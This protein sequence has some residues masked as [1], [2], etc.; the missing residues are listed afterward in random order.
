MRLDK[1]ISNIT[2]ISRKEIKK[3]CKENRVLV[4]GDVITDPSFKVNEETD[5]VKIDN[6]RIM[7]KKFVYYMLNK[8]KDC[9]CATND[10]KHL[11]VINLIEEDEYKDEIFP[12]GRLDKDTVGLLLITNDGM[13]AHNLLSPVKH[14]DKKYFV[15]VT[16][17]LEAEH[18]DVFKKGIKL[19]EDFITKP[20]K[21]EIL[22][23]SEISEAYVTIS[24]GKFHQIKRMF[25]SMGMVVIYLKRI[26]MGGLVLDENLDEGS[27]RELTEE[28]VMNL[29]NR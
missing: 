14:V 1:M 4:N 20:A 19:E 28:E 25:L 8:P 16:G 27:Y 12:V 21:L 5:V 24:E 13:L 26:S 15:R 9:I 2:S 6:K 10:K 7:Y 18:A 3:I 29:K 11:T 17:K 22:K 23:S